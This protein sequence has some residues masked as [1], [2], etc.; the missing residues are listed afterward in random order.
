MKCDA[1]TFFGVI[2]A[3]RSLNLFS[4]LPL[5][6]QEYMVMFVIAGQRKTNPEGS[7]VSMVI[8]KMHVPQPAVSRTLRGLENDG[9]ICREVCRTDRRN[10]Y[11]TLTAAG[12]AEVQRANQLLEDFHRGIQKRFTQEE[13][14]QL[15]EL[16]QRLYAAASEELEEMKGER[17]TNG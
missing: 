4:L 17:A 13:A 8:Q 16:L 6:R 2:N 1:K 12:E 7:T 9:Y 10:T 14:D 3:F 5:S 15:M 11:V